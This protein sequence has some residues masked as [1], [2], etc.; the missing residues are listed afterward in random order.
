MKQLIQIMVFVFLISGCQS[1]NRDNAEVY[2]LAKSNVDFAAKS[3]E[4][5]ELP[6]PPPPAP[7]EQV[8][9]T[10]DNNNKGADKKKIIKDGRMGMTVSDLSKTK[11]KTDALVKSHGGY[12]ESESLNN[13]DYESSYTL[14][15]RIPGSNFEK[16][17]AGIE[18]EDGEI[19][20]KTIDAR[21]VT[22]QFI[23]LETRLN[24]KRN[25]LARYNELLKKAQAVKDILEIEEKVR[26]LE[27]EIDSTIGRLKYLSDQVD[28]STLDLTITKEKEFK[29]NPASRDSFV[30]K[31]KQSISKGWYGFVDFILF[32]FNIWPFL[33]ITGFLIYFWKRFKLKL[34]LRRKI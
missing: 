6:P 34:R 23:D 18:S 29:Y 33:I 19:M 28:Y 5:K 14:K 10:G 15:V 25:Y 2:A 16:F 20:Y 7:E 13:S 27:E 3:E 32:L 31:L 8:S 4:V 26:G 24:T 9:Y 11:S 30:E 12:Y 17:I 22:D 1:K 21:D